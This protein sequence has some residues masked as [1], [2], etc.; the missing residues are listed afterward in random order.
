MSTYKLRFAIHKICVFHNP[1]LNYYHSHN[2]AK[3]FYL[4]FVLQNFMKR[5]FLWNEI[6]SRIFIEKFC[7]EILP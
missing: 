7:E 6:L 2:E 4:N 1:E 3:D 5:S